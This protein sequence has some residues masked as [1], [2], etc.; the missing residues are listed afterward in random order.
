MQ[1][2]AIEG[3][4]DGAQRRGQEEGQPGGEVGTVGLSGC[5]PLACQP[6]PR[7]APEPTGQAARGSG[8]TQPRL[9]PR[10]SLQKMEGVSLLGQTGGGGVPAPQGTREGLQGQLSLK[11]DY[12]GIRK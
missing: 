3:G 2:A 5:R 10:H 6:H 12:A 9:Q 8:L 11:R 4:R 1:G 7:Q